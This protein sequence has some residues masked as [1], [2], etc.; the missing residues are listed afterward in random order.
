[1]GSRC[2]NFHFKKPSFV[3]DD[4]DGVISQV[5]CVCC[6]QLWLNSVLFS[7][8]CLSF[9]VKWPRYCVFTTMKFSYCF[10]ERHLSS[11]ERIMARYSPCL[12]RPP[13]PVRLLSLGASW[14]GIFGVKYKLSHPK[15]NMELIRILFIRYL[16]L[17]PRMVLFN[18]GYIPGGCGNNKDMCHIS[19]GFRIRSPTLQNMMPTG[20]RS[21]CEAIPVTKYF[22]FLE[23]TRIHDLM[24]QFVI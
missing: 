17:G 11:G 12:L 7:S 14:W 3:D 18:K 4:D 20:L 10:H 1:M 2:C 22:L 15:K 21:S 16:V 5:A 6:L 9:C 23:P 13:P 24:S 19:R 8:Y